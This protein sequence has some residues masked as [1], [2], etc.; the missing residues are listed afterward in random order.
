MDTTHHASQ[1]VF[2]F[3]DYTSSRFAVDHCCVETLQV[4]FANK[5]QCFANKGCQRRSLLTMTT[6]FSSNSSASWANGVGVQL[7]L[8][9]AHVLSGNGIAEGCNQSIKRI[10][11]RKQC[12]VMEAVYRYKKT[13]RDAVS[14]QVHLSMRSTA[15]GYKSKEST[16]CARRVKEKCSVHTG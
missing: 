6:V 12:T 5:S 16:A 11:A 14:L 15:N 4:S 3:I 9:C 13:S 8:R 10:A 7:R 1:H 2:T